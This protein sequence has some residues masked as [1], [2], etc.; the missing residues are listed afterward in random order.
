MSDTTTTSASSTTDGSTTGGTTSAA[1]DTFKPIT[2]QDEFNEA[3]GGRVARERAKYAD[4]DDLKAKAA[5]LAEIEEQNKSDVQK[6]TDRAAA[7]EA[8]ATAAEGKALRM[9]IAVKHGI[10][11][12]NAALFL[13][14]T[15]EA[16]LNQQAERL[17]ELNK[18]RSTTSNTV[19]GEGGNPTATKDAKRAFLHRI[20]GQDT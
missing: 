14:G 7:A 4:Y 20:T 5:R 18:G 10:S 3:V 9:Q 15:D 6:A 8:K 1:T 13:T 11:E 2:T 16:S 17:A 12:E 19:T